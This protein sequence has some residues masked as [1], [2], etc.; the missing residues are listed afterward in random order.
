MRGI[1]RNIGGAVCCPEFPVFRRPIWLALVGP[2]RDDI[3]M[4]MTATVPSSAAEVV[5]DPHALLRAIRADVPDFDYRAAAALADAL[6]EEEMLGEMASF[7][8]AVTGV[9]NTIFISTKAG[10][11]HGPRVKVAINPPLHL[12]AGGETASVAFDGTVAAGNVPAWLLRQ[13]QAFIELNRAALTEYWEERIST[14][15]LQQQLRSI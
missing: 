15:E 2:Q 9:D 5:A 11:R 1:H 6:A 3:P 14:D 13:V 8:S 10:V 7:R 4:K 12:N